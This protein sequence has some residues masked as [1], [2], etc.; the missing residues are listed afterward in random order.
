MKTGV[1]TK[2]K[3]STVTILRLA[4]PFI[5]AAA[6]LTLVLTTVSWARDGLLAASPVPP[7]APALRP[8][9]PH[10][11]VYTMYDTLTPAD[12]PTATY[13]WV[14]ARLDTDY[15]WNLGGRYSGYN[16]VSDP[17][18]VGFVFP[19]YDDFYTHFRIS[20]K[21]YI[22]F[23]KEG[24]E[25]GSGRGWPDPIPSNNLTGTDAAN[26]FIAPFAANLCGYPELSY[27]YVRNDSSPRRTI[28]EFEN[29]VWCFGRYN[30]RTFEIVLYPDG[31]IDLH[32]L[33]ITNFAGTLD[34]DLGRSFVVGLENL[35]G[36][37]GDVY[38]QGLIF[39]PDA[40][41]YWRDEMA[42]RFQPNFT[43]VQALFLP[44]SQA[45]WDDPGN[46]ITA[47]PQLYLGASEEVTR[48]FI[49]TH[50]LSV[51]SSV[52]AA[53]WESGVIYPISVP[54]ITG[55]YS[56]TLPVVV[57]IPSSVVDVDDM[58]TLTITAQSADA[59]PFVSATY[60]LRYGPAHR[61]LQIVKTLAPDVPPAGGGALRYRL[62][63]LNT[64]YNDSGRAAI[65][66]GVVVTDAL[67]AG[68]VYEDCRRVHYWYC[69]SMITTTVV[70]S[71]TI[72]TLDLGS[73]YIDETETVWLE[74]RN[75]G[76]GVG[77]IVGNTAHVTTTESVELG[78][79]PNNHSGVTFTVASSATN[80]AIY[81]DYPQNRGFVAAGQAVP[82]NIWFHNAD[83]VPLYGATLVDLLPEYTTFDHAD[84][85]Y[86][87]PELIPGVEGP[88]TPTIGG[89]MSRTLTFDIPFIDNGHWNEARL[90]ILAYV[91]QTV[92]LGTGLTNLVTIS[93]GTG[94]VSAGV[95]ITIA[96]SYIDPFVDKEPSLDENDDVVLPV[97]GQDYTFWINYGNRSALTNAANVTITD[98]LP[99]S[100]TLVNVSAAPNLTRPVTSVSPEGRVQL[101]WQADPYLPRGW[102][103]QMAVVVHVDEGVRPGTELANR[104]EI[105]YTDEVYLPSTTLDD[106][107]VV[108][109]EVAS[110]LRG[111]QKLVDNP[112]PNA[113]ELV[114]YTLVVS[115]ASPT[116]TL[117]FTVLDVLPAELSY[118]AHYTPATGTVVTD[119][120]SI[121]WTGDVMAQDTVTLTFQAV[122]TDLA[123]V[124]QVI[125]NTAHISAADIYLARW[126]DVIV[127]G[128]V[129]RNSK[130]TYDPFG[131]IASGDTI[132]YTLVVQNDGT[133]TR[134]VTVTDSLPPSVTLVSGS[135][136][137]TTGT[138]LF[139]ALPS[140]VLTWTP[141]V[142]GRGSEQLDFQ[143]SVTEGLTAG[144][145]ITNVA[146]LDDGLL[147]DPW[148]L[149]VAFTIGE[150]PDVHLPVVL[151]NHQ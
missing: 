135:L 77:A 70:G 105:T 142:A 49:L 104:V 141:I 97:E 95:T 120:R 52:S 33:K 18:P 62:D 1:K 60:S 23:E 110:V 45:L 88:I 31:R 56:R 67:P 85:R 103:G 136:S 76:N 34:E 5:G 108:T 15:V 14:E 99:A 111:S 109:V 82:F 140:R 16:D 20:E 143:V 12:V 25:V 44:G 102:M 72:V 133:T 124:G 75:T 127:A 10:S 35:D 4:L 68:V 7:V 115:S 145:T 78:A 42:I 38:T 53:E 69:G 101:T 147:H 149:M 93:H 36:S 66:R 121:R 96:S 50:T 29:I 24:V 47:T 125:R 117:E 134:I 98:T 80:L 83:N 126:R 58:A 37:Q 54:A 3:V 39:A 137:P 131:G 79:G 106:V 138:V 28:I 64:D 94:Q 107:D 100:V 41:N 27:V 51:S 119:H 92:P 43:R 63:I 122:I 151:R 26:N 114:A 123:Y 148:P 40:E 61:D 113:G 118:A 128:S 57:R 73:M 81:K 9:D 11:G 55:T 112:A 17:Y 30:P 150:L 19:F 65:A 6:I 132:T 71:Q 86:E 2:V 116:G 74:L 48:S 144:V 89:P 90:E 59:T 129:F 13:E 46:T 146:Y 84:L 8:H 139:P 32:Y 21:G 87:G 91:P 22:F 130:K